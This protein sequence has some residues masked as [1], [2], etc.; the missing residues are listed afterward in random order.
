MGGI[1]R[2]SRSLASS[3]FLI[4]L[5][6]SP[7]EAVRNV[8]ALTCDFERGGC[9]LCRSVGDDLPDAATHPP[10]RGSCS[11]V[12]LI[13]EGCHTQ[14]KLFRLNEPKVGMLNNYKSMAMRYF[15]MEGVKMLGQWGVSVYG[16]GSNSSRSL[17]PISWKPRMI[18]EQL[19]PA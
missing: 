13:E 14:A 3:L 9:R 18:T 1:K 11:R 16:H 2:Q 8:A 12:D 4:S 5:N 15:E 10:K 7:S 17:A 19:M 6:Q